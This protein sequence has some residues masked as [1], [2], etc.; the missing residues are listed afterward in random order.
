MPRQNRLSNQDEKSIS[1]AIVFAR[2]SSS[3]KNTGGVGASILSPIG[4]SLFI[5]WFTRHVDTA[6][7]LT[8]LSTILYTKFSAKGNEK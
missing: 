8:Y 3:R 1:L 4:D 5:S 2:E 6:A 7:R